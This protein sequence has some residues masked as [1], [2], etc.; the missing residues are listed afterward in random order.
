MSR[1]RQRKFS[2]IIKS[3]S[4]SIREKKFASTFDDPADILDMITEVVK[5]IFPLVSVS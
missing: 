4:K 5:I 3:S 1:Y 2:K